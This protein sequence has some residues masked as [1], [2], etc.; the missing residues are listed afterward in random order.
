MT[1]AQNANEWAMAKV[2]TDGG[3][4]YRLD[5][6]FKNGKTGRSHQLDLEN[7]CF[8]LGAPVKSANRK[9]IK[10]LTEAWVFQR[11]ALSPRMGLF[12]W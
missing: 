5:I 11:T 9:S 6:T 10:A 3:D 8:R 4:L 7:R 2:R 1:N 12:G